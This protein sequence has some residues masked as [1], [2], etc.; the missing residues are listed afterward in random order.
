MLRY[1]M[2]LFAPSVEKCEEMIM[3][4]VELR[5]ARTVREEKVRELIG[6]IKEEKC[7]NVVHDG[8]IKSIFPSY[9]DKDIKVNDWGKYHGETP[10]IKDEAIAKKVR[11]FLDAHDTLNGLDLDTKRKKM[12]KKILRRLESYGDR[13]RY[14][15]FF[16]DG[17]LYKVSALGS[18]T[19]WIFGEVE[20]K[21]IHMH[22]PINCEDHEKDK[23]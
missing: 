16:I 20:Y 12:V 18:F 10:E 13:G 6:F 7:V 17:E 4:F 8:K 1:V 23:E 9:D 2:A 22:E 14:L 19:E 5:K 15:N 3:E 21:L 11:E